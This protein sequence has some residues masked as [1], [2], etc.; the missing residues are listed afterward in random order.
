MTKPLTQPIRLKSLFVTLGGIVALTIVIFAGLV[1]VLRVINPSE[2]TIYLSIAL[3]LV[4]HSVAVI[5]FVIM[6]VKKRAYSWNDLGFRKPK[7]NLW[8]LVWQLPIILIVLLI[9][10]GILFALLNTE[11]SSQSNTVDDIAQKVPVYAALLVCFSVAI[12]GPVWEEVV[13]RGIIHN[14][15]TSKM[16]VVYA[17]LLSSAIFAIVHVAPI[18]FP[19]LFAMGLAWAWLYH[20]Y[21]SLWAPIIGH[22][23]INMLATVTVIM[24][25]F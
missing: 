19:Y 24:Y 20:R 4:G 18:L 6:M 23:F 21:N 8:N 13:F 15:L 1:G 22:V 10:Q 11:P 14:Y 25:F 7:R 2:E 17:A 9:V 12:I 5:G 16:K 3:T